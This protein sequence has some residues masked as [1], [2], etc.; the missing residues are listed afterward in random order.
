VERSFHPQR[1]G[2]LLLVTKPFYFWS[3]KY[4]GQSTGTTHGTPHEYDTHVPL[5]LAGP[6]VQPGDHTRFVDMADLAPTLAAL[7]GIEAPAGTEGRVIA[8]VT[9]GE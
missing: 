6:G 3:S 2:D 9:D 4:G 5:L 8:E 1:S 7:L